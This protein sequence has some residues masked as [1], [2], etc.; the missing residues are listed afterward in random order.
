METFLSALSKHKEPSLDCNFGKAQCFL[1]DA[2]IGCKLLVDFNSKKKIQQAMLS[3]HNI[4]MVTFLSAL[5]KHK[6]PSLDCNF[7][8]AQCFLLNANIG[9]KLLV[10]FNSKK[11]NKQY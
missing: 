10:D 9:R 3:G 4:K 1:L 11:Y 2:N 8:K 6:E 7:G 5:S